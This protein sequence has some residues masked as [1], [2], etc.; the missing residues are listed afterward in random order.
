MG[1]CEY[2][3]EIEFIDIFA[4]NL[5]SLMEEVGITQAE[6]ADESGLTRATINRYLKKQRMPDLRALIN[7]CYILECEV[8]DLIP[9]YA[10]IH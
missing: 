1:K 8:T 10:L 9:T 6:L 3:S 2:I 4:D 5:R 7:I